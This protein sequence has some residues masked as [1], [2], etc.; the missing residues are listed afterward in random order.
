ML[1]LR[2]RACPNRSGRAE[3][4]PPIEMLWLVCPPKV[5][6]WSQASMTSIPILS[7]FS[8]QSAGTYSA[9]PSSHLHVVIPVLVNYIGDRIGVRQVSHPDPA[10]AGE[11]SRELRL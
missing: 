6:T 11:G 9:F 8:S 10:V 4:G 1:V 7:H 2:R 5:T 3:A